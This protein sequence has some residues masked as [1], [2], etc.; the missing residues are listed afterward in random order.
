MQTPCGGKV[1]LRTKGVCWADAEDWQLRDEEDFER[2]EL[3]A[4]SLDPW[5]LPVWTLIKQTSNL[6]ET[7]TFDAEFHF[8]SDVS[9]PGFPRQRVDP[10]LTADGADD[11][12]LATGGVPT[13]SGIGTWAA[14]ELLAM[15][16]KGGGPSC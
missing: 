14:S 10:E 7:F 4:A 12:G 9:V 13:W 16:C 3:F 11:P 6:M 15:V 5:S 2:C 8:P 1:E